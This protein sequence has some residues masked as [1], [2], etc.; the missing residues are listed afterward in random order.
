MNNLLPIAASCLLIG[1][2]VGYLFGNQGADAETTLSPESSATSEKSS[3]NRAPGAGVALDSGDK[4]SSYAEVT[5]EPGQ[6]ARLQALLE[7]YSG[8][9]NEEFVNEAKKL[10][11]LPFNERILASYFLF[12]AWAE[13]SPY[14]A[15]EHAGSQMGPAGMF[16]RPTILQSWAA[17][18][19]QGAAT[20]YESNKSEFAMMRMMGRGQG[21]MSSGPA[22]IAG[23]WAKQDPEGALAWAKTLDGRDGEEAMSKALSQIATTDP[24][25]ASQLTSGLEGSALAEANTSIAREWA[26]KDWSATESWVK[27]LPAA[28]Q[29]DALS[30]AVSS[31]A[32]DDPKLA[33]TKA[34]QIPE[35]SARDKAIENVTRSMAREN[36]AQA[37]DWVMKNGSEK[38]QS[39]AMGDSMGSWVATDSKAA[40]AFVTAQPEGPVRDAAASSYVINDHAGQGADQVVLAESITDDRSRQWSVG[41]ATLR[42]MQQDK[43]AASTYLESTEAISEDAKSRILDR[44]DR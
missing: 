44:V 7:L 5:A 36:P 43:V 9:N 8:L 21:G 20:Y 39:D 29:D 15:L 12:A 13:V 18:D 42:W 31:L 40:Q 22:T 14:D 41:V 24:L 26:L 38:A 28:Q 6:T 10:D 25:K 19:P 35:G 23:E 33:G 17:T 34:L 2:G 32:D 27:S 3:R 11:N 1:G 30:S 16:V 4:P 37:V